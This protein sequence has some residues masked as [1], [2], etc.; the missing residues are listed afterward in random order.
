[1]SPGHQAPELTGIVGGVALPDTGSSRPLAAVLVADPDNTSLTASITVQAATG[2]LTAASSMG[3]LRSSGASGQ[4]VYSRTF[5]DT[6]LLSAAQAAQNALQSLVF[7]PIAYTLALAGTETDSFSVQVTDSS[8]ISSSVLDGRQT[9]SAVHDLPFVSGSKTTLLS[10]TV[11]ASL[12]S[13]TSVTDPDNTALTLSVT[14]SSSGG[15]LDGDLAPESRVGWT[16]SAMENG[17]VVYTRYLAGT[18]NAGSNAQALL[19]SLVFEPTAHAQ[20][21]GSTQTDTVSL[22][23]VDALGGRA[24]AVSDT[25]DITASQDSVVL[26]GS[27][28]GNTLADNGSD[29]PF[30]G[31]GIQDPDLTALLVSVELPVAA[32][33]FTA[34]STQGWTQSLNTQGVATWTL[35]VPA[36]TN[37]ALIAQGAINALVF[38]ASDHVALPGTITP[39]SYDIK[40]SDGSAN[41][42]PSLDGVDSIV[43]MEDAPVLA[44]SVGGGVITD[45]GAD[46]PFQ[47]VLVTDPDTTALTLRVTVEA[48]NGDLTASSTQ[49]WTRD[50]SI[51]ASV[52]YTET[53]PASANA[54]TSAQLALQSLVFQP[55][56]HALA[57]GTTEVDS[58][59][60]DVQDSQGAQTSMLVGSDTVA[61][62]HDI[63][64]LTGN[65]A[66]IDFLDTTSSTPFGNASILDSDN[67]ML[68]LRV[69]V[70]AANGDMT[71]AS[72]VGFTR[73]SDGRGH[74]VYSQ[75]FSS[76]V[77]SA[78]IA[79][80]ALRAMV[81][82]PLAHALVAGDSETDVFSATVTDSL[83]ATSAPRSGAS[84]VTAVL[85]TP[86]VGGV[87]GGLGLLDVESGD[88][89]ASSL[90]EDPD[91]TAL[92][93]VV[94]VDA[95]HGNLTALSTLGWT[96]G[97]GP[98]GSKLWTLYLPAQPNAGL[99]AQA[100]L[101]ALVFQPAAHAIVAGSS[102]VDEFGFV[103]MD[104][105]HTVS[106]A[107]GSDTVRAVRDAV[108]L[109][110][111]VGGDTVSDGSL[112][113]PF[114]STTIDDPDT[115]AL[116]LSVV[117]DTSAGDLSAA[118]TM[119]WTR[120]AD[121]AL[122]L[123]TYTLEIPAQGGADVLAQAAL[124]GLVFQA[125][126]HMAL[127]GTQTRLDYSVAVQDGSN[128]L[129]AQLM[130]SSTVVAAHSV[131][132]VTGTPAGLLIGGSAT[133][134]PFASVGVVE[135]D[136]DSLTLDVVE[137]AQ[138]G[139]F[140]A[141]SA[142]EWSR[143]VEQSGQIDYTRTFAAQPNVGDAAQGA[144]QSLVFQPAPH[145]LPLGS[146]ETDTFLIR[147]RDGLGSSSNT[148]SGSDTVI[149][150]AGPPTISGADSQY[151]LLDTQT[152][153]PFASTRVLDMDN[154]PLTASL[155]VAMGD[156]DFTAASSRG[157][158]RTVQPDGSVLYTQTFANADGVLATASADAALMALVF[159]PAVIDNAP[160]T[161][162]TSM[163]TAQVTDGYQDTSNPLVVTEVATAIHD[164][165]IVAN[166]GIGV[167]INDA[168]TTNPFSST[169]VV[170]PDD[171]SMRLLV[172]VDAAHGS[173]T[174]ASTAG[175]TR[176]VNPDGTV[177]YSL[178]LAAQSNV[179]S[180]AQSAI[181]ALVFQPV[182]HSI[183]AGTTETDTLQFQ[184]TD[185]LGA[186]A[187][188]GL[189]AQVPG[190]TVL[191]TA[192]RS[193]VS[194]SGV[195]AGQVLDDGT[196][197]N[198]FAD[199]LVEDPDN[200]VLVVEVT[201][202]LSLGGLDFQSRQGW[203]ANPSANG[204]SVVYSLNVASSNTAAAQV[205]AA[206]ES[207]VFV[208]ADN[209]N[210]PGTYA[211]A[212][213]MVSVTD[214]V[215]TSTLSGVDTVASAHNAAS[216]SG[217]ILDQGSNTGSLYPYPLLFVDDADPSAIVTVT[218]K[219]PAGTQG[220]YAVLGMGSVD[221]GGLAYTVT[222]TAAEVTAALHALVFVPSA[223]SSL[224]TTYTASITGNGN[225][226]TL[227]DA[228]P[229]NDVLSA[230]D[231]G[232]TVLAGAGQD[233][234]Y[235]AASGGSELV[236]G[237][238]HDT[239]IG[240]GGATT[241][242][243]GGAG[244]I[245][246]G[247][248]ADSTLIQG[249]G[250]DTFYSGSGNAV[251]YGGSGN[252]LAYGGSDNLAFIGGS[253]EETV[254]GA[255]GNNTVYGGSQAITAYGNGSGLYE[256]GTSGQN[257]IL[258]GLG[259][260][261]LVG[262]GDTDLL[263]ALGSSNDLL[264][265]GSGQDTLT[266]TN[267]LGD[268]TYIGGSGNTLIAA[269][270]GHSLVIGG[271]GYDT[272]YAGS[273]GGDLT[274][275]GTSGSDEVIGSA[276]ADTFAVGSGNETLIGSGGTDTYVLNAGHAGGMITIHDFKVGVD[277]VALFG[278]AA[279]E[280][281][282]TEAAATVSGGSTS[283]AFSDGTRMT[284]VG[285]T[286]IGN[287]VV[288]GND[289]G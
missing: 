7:E 288:H 274:Y 79:Q 171:T 194:V 137:T 80:A 223:G 238:G 43:A 236:G 66:G 111:H 14:L 220:T 89:F 91:D 247:G 86:T 140:T 18:P 29:K 187:T 265:A 215:T 164:I 169:L 192:L 76:G 99:G 167:S 256:G 84:T 252:G 253:G 96:P 148:V 17:S 30:Q 53:L 221:S 85:D 124:Q 75:T 16:R 95:L 195:V 100:A 263:V 230:M 62:L 211:L 147:A 224:P 153:N 239:F 108:V 12:F 158:V 120:T 58:F 271:S 214:G 37:A 281:N 155:R 273:G 151:D 5:A 13:A 113:T 32:G 24:S 34:S 1:M 47:G 46:N 240:A 191:V 209:I 39:E 213:F 205:Q 175:W 129:P 136:D 198:P 222:G 45:A 182:E 48:A 125:L 98:N 35:S 112:D 103:V 2:D 19:Q 203:T 134:K 64:V 159:Q 110:G 248:S 65:I 258:S 56:A 72:T 31:V 234:I 285:V 178:Q 199:V 174:Q 133:S 92:T 190:N 218:A 69:S 250:Q 284:F 193:A 141:A 275:F 71:A 261:T 289:A 168:S 105:T 185:G 40:V 180:I 184:V 42:L 33:N 283:L 131:P 200:T 22:E 170:D 225:A 38:Q 226:P 55:T 73:V 77:D 154:T 216:V 118:S 132:V 127:P 173:L 280:V 63:P 104:G 202:P 270:P 3:F 50:S 9:V 6:P 28:G 106:S 232:D 36:S 165:P 109:G 8:G 217:G 135:P 121:A 51:P 241:V 277:Q 276:I 15:V 87:V 176:T 57:L 88:P 244:S 264:V 162:Q 59:M 282:K 143:T 67:T 149:S 27:I 60:V 237:L 4:V 279:T 146:T 204:Q 97:I 25:L 78:L 262:G 20:A 130:G 268:N 161:T 115:T 259:S 61:P 90:V 152:N 116:T 229:G 138:N 243:S 93:L 74:V 49:G 254:I 160:G 128:A 157:F 68:V 26:S 177:G 186:Q 257:T 251:V 208:A 83:G 196:S 228:G 166:T 82:Q 188:N 117:V 126:D 11:T 227:I 233:T 267:S 123:A 119:G 212:D 114:Q 197:S 179:G 41:S 122:A 54:G 156:G 287:S 245:Y 81:F 260:S 94:S 255:L 142:M 206:L 210:A 219:L 144:L 207:L 145:A 189:G 44:G 163:I 150:V 272:V 101:Q 278:Y 10:D 286:N 249:S 23:V 21:P 242:F 107:S 172:V 269:G 183:P 235:G 70:A 246:Y 139:D 102:E 181:Q 52:V 231:N 266:G 201:V